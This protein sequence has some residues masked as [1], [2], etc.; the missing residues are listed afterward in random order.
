MRFIRALM[1]IQVFLNAL[2]FA[3]EE[4]RMLVRRLDESLQHF[5]R[6]AK[7]LGELGVLLILPGITQGR[8]TR[9]Q[10]RHAVL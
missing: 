8:E 4:G 1:L 6:V 10:E 2:G 9:L 3:Q 5:H 7:F